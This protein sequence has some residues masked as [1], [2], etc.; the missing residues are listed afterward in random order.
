MILIW[1]HI[2]RKQLCVQ[3][4]SLV[5]VIYVSICLP[6]CLVNKLISIIFHCPQ[7]Y[8]SGVHYICYI[9]KNNLTLVAKNKIKK[10]R[11]NFML[12]LT[13]LSFRDL[14]LYIWK[15]NLAAIDFSWLSKRSGVRRR[16]ILIFPE[17]ILKVNSLMSR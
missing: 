17:H 2:I 5:Y 15:I 12:S 10:E 1:W 14:L 11:S 9:Q 7:P 4:H 6:V 3:T 8:N 13:S 16:N